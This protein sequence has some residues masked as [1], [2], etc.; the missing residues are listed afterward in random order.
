MGSLRELP[1]FPLNTVLF[2][3]M[4]QPLHIFEPR[5][6]LMISAC[7]EKNRPFGAV[8]IKEGSGIGAPA[9]PYE[10]GTSAYVTQVERADDG[11]MNIQTVGYQ[12]FKIHAL[13][14]HRPYLIGLVEDYPLPGEDDPANDSLTE[15]LGNHLRTYFDVLKKASE[16]AVDL[17][18]IPDRSLALAF[19][20]AIILPLPNHEKQRMLA[21]DDLPKLLQL[22]TLLVRREIMLLRHMIEHGQQEGDAEL[23]SVN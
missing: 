2:P 8:L 11:R 1:L 6:R 7:V 10:V 23:F 3:G 4:N 16:E 5:Y 9:V 14:R 21:V 22:E 15:R 20:T 13:Q 17:D 18:T 12:R 19:L